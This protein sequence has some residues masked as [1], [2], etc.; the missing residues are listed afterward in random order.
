LGPFRAKSLRSRA[1]LSSAVSASCMLANPHWR[2][3][4]ASVW[5][6]AEAVTE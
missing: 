4:F 3:H 2:L 1:R 5:D 6:L